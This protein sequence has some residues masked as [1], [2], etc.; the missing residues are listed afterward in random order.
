VS[1][2]R[3][4]A[5][6]RDPA[7]FLFHDGPHVRRAVTE[8]GLPH[9]RAVRATGLVE[10]LVASGRLWPER[11]V[12]SGLDGHPDV[13]LVL[14]HP[15]LPFVSYPYEWPFRALQAAA[16]LHLDIQMEALD[17]GVVLTDASAYNVQLV[18]ARP[19]FID[20]LAFR[21]YGDGELWAAHRQFC[22]QFL[23]PLLLQSLLGVEFQPWYRGRIDGIPGDELVRL[24]P[25]RQK[26][27]WNVLTNV[28]APVRL[29]RLAGRPGME[30][31]VA[32][33]RMPKDGLRG[34]FS[35]LR[36]WIAQLSPR[37]LDRT[38]WAGYD[39]TVPDDESRA[40]AAFVD[41]FARQVAPGL[42]WDLGCNTGRYAEVALQAGA[43]YVVGIDSDAGA[44][45]RAFARARD[46]ELALLPLLVDLVNPSPGQG[47]R[48]EE[49]QG[50]VERGRP[51]A[52]L[53]L[54]VVHHMAIAR[55][56][57]LPEIVDL[58]TT[59]APEGVVGF[60]PSTDARARQLFRGRDEI[61]RE[62]TFENFLGLL[63]TRARV[64]RQEAV[65]GGERMLVWFSTRA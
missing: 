27:R 7:G 37:G 35:S 22:E 64:I 65:P 39:T 46:W 61:F 4:P 53:A 16:L 41:D 18:G 52:L 40:I 51:D 34:M 5:S 55:N 19:V 30:R 58:L 43:R 57:P 9:V 62:Y 2:H 6:F 26:L 29:Q 8:Y 31:R 21:P 36:Q 20:H 17:A 47:W 56:V 60:V 13:R 50:L 42:L 12:A 3:H 28:V 63:R 11:E 23:H 10:G 45:D 15:P 33:A 44:L 48:G 24:L 49:R 32:R 54:A 59:L 14:E 1:V 25:W 38:T